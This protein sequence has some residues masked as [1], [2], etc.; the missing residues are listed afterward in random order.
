MSND[1]ITRADNCDTYERKTSLL[2]AKLQA[3]H[4]DI[5]VVKVLR[6]NRGTEVSNIGAFY[7]D[8]GGG[9]RAAQLYEGG[10]LN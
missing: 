9:R 1:C 7:E 2:S 5:G 3:V 6:V 10:P 4:Q 8:N